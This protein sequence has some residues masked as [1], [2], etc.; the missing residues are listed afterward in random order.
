MWDF[1]DKAYVITLDSATHR[2]ARVDRE[3]ERV[4]LTNKAEVVKMRR[5][6]ISGKHGCWDSHVR[7]VDQAKRDG[8]RTAL[9]L[10]DD[11]QFTDDYDQYL[12][13]ARQFVE[14]MPPDSWDFLLLGLF[15]VDTSRAPELPLPSEVQKHI[16]RVG[17]GWQ[18]HAYIVNAPVIQAGLSPR[19]YDPAK[20]QQ[21]D[22]RLFCGHTDESKQF[23]YPRVRG[24]K[25]CVQG[26]GEPL[27]RVYAL[28]PQIV[29]QENDGTSSAGELGTMTYAFGNIKVMRGIQWMSLY[30]GDTYTFF[31]ILCAFVA[32]LF[33]LITLCIILGVMRRQHQ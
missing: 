12:Q 27:Y 26:P 10:E 19:E 25:S 9:V 14:S 8:A 22:L 28:A 31:T 30:G 16:V 6:P 4:Q 23:L 1:V 18:T 2:H 13:Y 5:H 3:L 17:C 20:K 15:A 24:A 32:L 29:V 33:L 7:I 21:I 11:F